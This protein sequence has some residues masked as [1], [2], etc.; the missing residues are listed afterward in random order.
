MRR[1]THAGRL[2]RWLGAEQC[3]QISASMRDWYGSPILVGNVPSVGGVW[4]RAGGDFVGQMRGGGFAGMIDY[5][6]E[7]GRAWEAARRAR[8]ERLWRERGLLE[9]HTFG[10]LSDIIAAKAA[11]KGRDFRLNKVGTTGVANA[12]N[13]LWR[14]GNLPSAGAAAGAAPG[15]TAPTDATTGAFPFVNPTGGDTLH[16]VR[17]D[18]SA[19]VAGNCLLMYDRIFEV[20]K[21]MSST[22]T[23]AVTGVPT[24]Y[25]STTPGDQD[26]AGNNFLFIEAQAALGATAHNWTTCLYN[27]QAGAGSTLPSLTGNSG[28]IINRLDHPVGQ[29]CAPLAA[30]DTGIKA[31]TQMQ[32]SASV[33]GTVAFVI[34]HPI[35]ILPTVAAYYWS[36]IDGINGAFNLT[37]IFDDAALAFIELMKPATTATT[38]NAV[39]TAVAG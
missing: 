31:L 28:C 10:S 37:R 23:E 25:Q 18:I 34:G 12:A 9:A 20:A 6:R 13:T 3:E 29:W 11:G 26:Y 22:A 32:C 16:F 17:G 36:I 39:V 35:V 21:T 15:G 1:S 5:V 38:Y 33:T 30:G 7:K 19:S 2:E 27:D 8:S 24:R 4:A 14:V